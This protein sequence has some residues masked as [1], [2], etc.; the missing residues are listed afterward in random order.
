MKLFAELACRI[1]GHKM[2]RRKE[3]RMCLRCGHQIPVKKR[4]AKGAV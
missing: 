2:S 1:F 3:F 4:V